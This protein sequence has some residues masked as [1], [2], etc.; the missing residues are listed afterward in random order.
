V[1]LLGFSNITICYLHVLFVNVSSHSVLLREVLLFFKL[2]V[3]C[4]FFTKSNVH[5]N[6]CDVKNNM[7]LDSVRLCG[8]YTN[9]TTLF[10]FWLCVLRDTG[11]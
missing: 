11:L 3:T 5:K 8:L 1:L 7:Q 10:S 4:A 9:H 6:L 2:S